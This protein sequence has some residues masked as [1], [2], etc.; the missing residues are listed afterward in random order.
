MFTLRWKHKIQTSLHNSHILIESSCDTLAG[1]LLVGCAKSLV[2]FGLKRQTLSEQ[3]SVLDF[4]RVLILH[5]QGW[6]PSQVSFCAGFIA[7]Q[8]ELE[9]L[10][11]KLTPRQK[12][13]QSAEEHTLLPEDIMTETSIDEDA[14]ITNKKSQDVGWLRTMLVGVDVST[15]QLTGGNLSTGR[16]FG[17]YRGYTLT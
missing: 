1:D 14:G 10:V 17:L 8:T 5:V 16:D 3:L 13:S 12:S 6:S 9:V 15:A 7:L 2:V 4:E 11:V